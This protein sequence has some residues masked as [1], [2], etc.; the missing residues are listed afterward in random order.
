[1][2]DDKIKSS[3][4]RIREIDELYNNVKKF[5]STKYSLEL[6]EFIG[7]FPFV[8]P[9]NAMLVFMQKPGSKFVTTAKIWKER[10]GRIPKSDA[11]PLII[12]QTF[13]PVSF[14]FELND[15]E[16]DDVPDEILNPFKTDDNLSS[17]KFRN[18][19]KCLGKEVIGYS[20]QNYGT[21]FAGQIIR[22]DKP[23][24]MIVGKI[25]KISR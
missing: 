22:R 6:L 11:R 19:K 23:K 10:F 5:R 7:K 3:P 2:K 1:M 24:K 16:G 14:V 25:K 20:E 21:N 9:Y 8:S 12:L 13:G 4:F 17:E 18:L 15:T